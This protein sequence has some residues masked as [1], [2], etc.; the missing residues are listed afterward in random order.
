MTSNQS[1]KRAALALAAVFVAGAALG[2]AGSRFAGRGGH[3]AWEMTAR[4]YRSHLLH[5]L[6]S[7]LDLTE[8]QQG[9]V[10]GILDEI[11]DRFESVRDAIEPEMEAIR[12]ERTE[13]IML[14]LEPSQRA[15]YEVI[16]EER[17][18]RRERHMERHRR[19]AGER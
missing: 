16:L 17:S 13:R 11:G 14:V 3:G 2:F 18:R 12:A 9:K 1:K 19:G 7:R 6:V 5:T 15:K 8:D 10:E 4:Q